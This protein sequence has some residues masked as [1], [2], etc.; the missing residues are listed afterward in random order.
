ML[1]T[2]VHKHLQWLYIL[3]FTD[4]YALPFFWFPNYFEWC[5]FWIYLFIF[6]LLQKG[7]LIIWLFLSFIGQV[8]I[9]PGESRESKPENSI[10][11][12]IDIF[13]YNKLNA[14]SKAVLFFSF[15]FF[16]GCLF[17]GLFL[18]SQKYYFIGIKIYVSCF[19][20]YRPE[21]PFHYIV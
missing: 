20:F 6:Y 11:N 16:F 5:F 10:N 21:V 1:L 14:Y 3:F 17:V 19:S 18:Y 7:Y 9:K 4:W 15:F 12:I 2:L 8:V 13:F